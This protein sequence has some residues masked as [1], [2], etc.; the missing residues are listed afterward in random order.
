[1]A[2]AQSVYFACALRATEFLLFL[3]GEHFPEQCVFCELGT[4]Y[5]YVVHRQSGFKALHLGLTLTGI[6]CCGQ[7]D[8]SKEHNCIKPQCGGDMS[9]D[10]V[11]VRLQ[12][13]AMSQI[14]GPQFRQ[15]PPELP[16]REVR[17]Q[18]SCNRNEAA[19]SIKL[20]RNPH[21]LY[22]VT[23]RGFIRTLKMAT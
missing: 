16:A 3:Y 14:A 5:C 21:M 9:L 19:C 4:E 8:F 6:F 17:F 7:I 10:S 18:R 2:V 15:S 20:Q 22:P 13:C 23:L 12:D 1:V 11:H